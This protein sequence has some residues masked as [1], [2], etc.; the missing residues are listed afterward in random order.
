MN[1][2]AIGKKIPQNSEAYW[3]TV[4]I[5][6]FGTFRAWNESSGFGHTDT[7]VLYDTVV[8]RGGCVPD[9]GKQ[10][11]LYIFFCLEE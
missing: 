9:D 11:I 6:I 4:Q 2:F 10:T 1:N 3:Q 5:M 8:L 7:V